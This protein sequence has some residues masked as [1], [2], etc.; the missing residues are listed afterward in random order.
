MRSAAVALVSVSVLALPTGAIAATSHAPTCAGDGH[1][2]VKGT[3]AT[4]SGNTAT[5]V[6][7]LAVFHPCGPDDGHFTTS[8]Q[9]ITL[10][11][12]SST[13]ITVFKNEYNPSNTKTVTAANFPA[14]FEKNKDE[15]FYRYTG[16]KSC[17]GTLT[18]KFVP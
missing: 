6:G 3:K 18:E 2:Y 16:T 7:K 5:F 13:K 4:A 8:T 12:M 17:V 9:T 10:T 11:L 15:P 14:S 1:K